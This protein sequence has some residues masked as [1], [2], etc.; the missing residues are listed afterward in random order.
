MN[1]MDSHNDR[2]TI[3]AFVS[4]LFFTVRIDKVAEY[5]NYSLKTVSQ[6]ED[7]GPASLTN[8]PEQSYPGERLFGRAG[9]LLDH[10]TRWQPAL[11]I[12]DLSS[13]EIPWRE[14]LPVIKSSPATRRLPVLCYGAH[15]DVATLQEARNL[16]ADEVVPRSR[17]S[18]AM[19]ELIRKHARIRDH[20]R[21]ASACDEPLAATAIKGIELMNAGEFFDAHEE[22][23]HAWMEDQGAGRDLYRGIL[24]VAVAYYQIQRNNYNG[25][26]KMFLR[27]RQWLDPLPDI[28]RG[29][30]V[31]Q[32]RA[33][34]E[35]VQQA[36]VTLGPDR[37]DTFDHSL[38][39]P[40]QYRN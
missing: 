36:L 9:N 14:W 31:A 37:L 2:P 19:P 22:L 24:Q 16:G 33:D 6:A 34:A 11:L 12:F 4:D 15:V 1:V 29:V 3:V 5:L 17:F 25:A 35:A 28:C 38:F 21:L 40:V 13:D 20:S 18:S 27:V 8:K 10:L 39:R 7:V 32:L 23:E 30:N 26:A